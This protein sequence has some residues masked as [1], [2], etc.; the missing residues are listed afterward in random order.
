MPRLLKEGALS[1][2]S[3]LKLESTRAAGEPEELSEQAVENLENGSG[4]GAEV[5]SQQHENEASV[6]LP[7]VD[8]LC[9]DSDFQGFMDPR[10]DDGLRRAA[11]KKLFSDPHFNVS[12]G[13]DVYAE[14]YTKLESM[15]PAMVAG[16]RHARG[17]LFGDVDGNQ[18]ADATHPANN[19]ED[20]VADEA[21]KKARLVA[22]EEDR[23]PDDSESGI[24]KTQD[25]S[26]EQDSTEHGD[27][28]EVA[29]AIPTAS[30]DKVN[31]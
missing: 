18:Q 23:L 3:R 28:E 26:T 7:P 12:D 29:K 8:E 30:G 6:E 10:V 1:R 9:A 20:A 22:H 5:E 27:A 24:G 16:L 19:I 2:W 4:D 25:G 11:L 13:L 14:D 17:L 15:T 21:S 31:V